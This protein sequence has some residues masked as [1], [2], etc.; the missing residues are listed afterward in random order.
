MA[1]VALRV[2]S[3]A[4]A[5]AAPASSSVSARKRSPAACA[6]AA[7][8]SSRIRSAFSCDADTPSPPNAQLT[9]LNLYHQRRRVY[10]PAAYEWFIHH[11]AQ[12]VMLLRPTER[13]RNNFAAEPEP[14]RKPAAVVSATNC[15]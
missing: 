3:S 14:G 6:T 8:S 7:N 1:A 15:S 12:A 13:A 9:C 4:A 10:L 2:S 11:L 5:C